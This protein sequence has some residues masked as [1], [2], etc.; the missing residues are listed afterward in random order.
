MYFLIEN[1][2]LLEKYNT[3]FNKVGADIEKELDSE[4]FYYKK[5]R[6]IN[7]RHIKILEECS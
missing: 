4:P 2:E 6:H 3:V 5:I 1:G 7:D